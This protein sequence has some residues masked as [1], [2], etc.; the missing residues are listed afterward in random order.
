MSATNR[1]HLE[2]L[3]FNRD[4][5]ARL[6][7]PILKFQLRYVILK[8]LEFKYMA[9]KHNFSMSPI[10]NNIRYISVRSAL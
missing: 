6:P 1:F 2:I 3:I 4:F 9:S 10:N 8:F 7:R 5:F